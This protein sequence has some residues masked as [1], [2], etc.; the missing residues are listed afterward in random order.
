MP[1]HDLEIAFDQPGHPDLPVGRIHLQLILT[2][3]YRTLEVVGHEIASGTVEGQATTLKSLVFRAQGLA[4]DLGVEFDVSHVGRI[5]EGAA[6]DLRVAY[7]SATE[8]Y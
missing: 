1:R 4:E 3:G 6:K 2:K 5:I 8:I 7:A